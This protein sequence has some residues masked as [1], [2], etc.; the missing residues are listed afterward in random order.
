MRHTSGDSSWDGTGVVSRARVGSKLV[1]FLSLVTA[2]LDP[3]PPPK[4]ETMSGD[5]HEA[6]SGMAGPGWVVRD[7]HEEATK[8]CVSDGQERTDLEREARQ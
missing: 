2:G 7:E 8:P 5:F 4:N 6:A 1:S 3:L